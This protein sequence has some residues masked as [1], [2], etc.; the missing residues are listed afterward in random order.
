MTTISVA[1][2][3]QR[4][5]VINEFDRAPLDDERLFSDALCH[6]TRPIPG[7][8]ITWSHSVVQSTTNGIKN[9]VQMCVRSHMTLIETL[10]YLGRGEENKF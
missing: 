10:H 7:I 2:G 3:M 9:I 6:S 5:M 8:T 4:S 1:W